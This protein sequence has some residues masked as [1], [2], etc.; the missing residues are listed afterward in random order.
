[1]TPNA[2]LATT[3]IPCPTCGE[4]GS[5]EAW[6]GYMDGADYDGNRGHWVEELVDISCPVCKGEC[7]ITVPVDVCPT[8]AHF[9]MDPAE[10]CQCETFAYPYQER[11]APGRVDSPQSDEQAA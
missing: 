9:F 7:V 6:D 10:R 8:C 3:V 11:R 4:T 2:K 1:M 5:I